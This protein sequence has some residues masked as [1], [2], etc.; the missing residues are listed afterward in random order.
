MD[1]FARNKSIFGADFAKLGEAKVLLLGVG[2]VGSF[3]LDA[4]WRTGVTNLTIVDFDCYDI[5]NQNRQLGSEALGAPK[6]YRLVSLYDGVTPIMAKVTPEWVYQFDFTS[7]DIILD[8]IDDV[9]AKVA[10]AHKCHKKLI[11]SMGSAKRIDPT[12]IE[13]KSIWKVEGDALARCVKGG[14]KKLPIK[15]DFKAICSTEAPMINDK[16]SF[17]GVTGAFGLTLASECIKKIIAI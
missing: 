10:V 3:C 12:K 14:L 1:R 9:K 17:V 4:L 6:V 5:T 2:G 16:G 7:Y 13:V 8:A 11:A 15:V